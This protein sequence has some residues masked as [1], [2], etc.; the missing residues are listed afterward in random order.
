MTSSAAAACERACDH[1]AKP[2]KNDDDHIKCMGFCNQITH[3]KCTKLNAPFFKIV[4]EKANLFWMCCECA[5]LMKL[6]RF[7]TAMTA[8]NNAI[9]TN[10]NN[11]EVA[12][13]ELKQAITDNSRQIELLSRKVSASTPLSSRL[14]SGQPASKRRRE[15]PN[16]KPLIV[17]TNANNTCPI[18]TVSPPRQQFRLYLSRIHP[19]VKTD[20]V[21][22][23][24]KECLQCEDPLKVIPLVKKDVDLGSLNFISFKIELLEKYREKA[25]DPSTWP[26]GILFREFENGNTKNYWEPSRV[27]NNVPRIELTPASESHQFL[28]PMPGTSTSHMDSS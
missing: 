21:I 4:S 22:N 26:R 19:S 28:P 10:S 23:L 17:G 25:L 13:T 14:T 18:Q 7:K 2:A 6:T 24:A 11:Q 8:I 20:E 5:N 27:N 15:E 16:P 9:T 3:I 1:C 12:I